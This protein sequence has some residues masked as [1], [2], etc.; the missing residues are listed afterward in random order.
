[1]AQATSWLPIEVFTNR[2]TVGYW[3]WELP[4][5][6]E[7]WRPAF[8]LVQE[9][10]VPSTFV[11]DTISRKAPVPVV[12]IPH[13][14]RIR[15]DRSWTGALRAAARRLP[16]PHDVRLPQRAE[17]KNPH[18]AIRAFTDSFACDDRVCRS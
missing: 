7:D 13:A 5:F 16:V 17:R 11:L 3:V 15:R 6:P 4:E 2:Y 18:G 14:I 12:R 8:E 1:M 10:W 9:V